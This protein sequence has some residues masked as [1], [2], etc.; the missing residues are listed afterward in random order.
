MTDD[1][2][3]RLRLESEL[4]EVRRRERD[5][6]RGSRIIL[7]LAIWLLPLFGMELAGYH[8]KPEVGPMSIW[9]VWFLAVPAAFWLYCRKN[10]I[11]ES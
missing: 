1:K 6:A 10:R 5:N 8:P 4:R 2:L 7:F 11:D 3:E 9:G